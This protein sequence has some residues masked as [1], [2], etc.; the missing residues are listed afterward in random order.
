M[1]VSLHPIQNYKTTI[2]YKIIKQ[3][4]N[5]F[6]MSLHANRTLLPPCVQLQNSSSVVPHVN[7]QY[8]PEVCQNSPLAFAQ[9]YII[10]DCVL[11]TVL[12]QIFVRC[13]AETQVSLHQLRNN[14]PMDH[15]GMNMVIQ[16]I[17]L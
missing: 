2:L 16:V 6:I 12:E 13:P 9:M 5:G 14:P 15:S 8:G 1:D 7:S 10:I 4:T 11:C 17:I 3:Q